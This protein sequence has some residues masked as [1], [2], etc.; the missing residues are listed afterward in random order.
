[1]PNSLQASP[2]QELKDIGAAL[3][4]LIAPDQAAE[5]ALATARQALVEFKKIGAWAQHV[6]KSNTTRADAY[7]KLLMVPSQ[8]PAQRLASD[9]QE[10]F[11]TTRAG[12]AR[13]SRRARTRSPRR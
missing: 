6:E 12:G 2:H 9:Y 11:S 8:N 7:G 5:S 4:P 1:M 13:A 3:V 10:T